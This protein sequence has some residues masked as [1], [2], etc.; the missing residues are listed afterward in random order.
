[1]Y[2]KNLNL[3]VID[4]PTLVVGF[5]TWNVSLG[6]YGYHICQK[7]QPLGYRCSYMCGSFPYLECNLE[8]IRLPHVCQKPQPLGYRC[9]YM[10]G[11]F[12]YLQCKLGFMRLPH[13]CQKPQPLGYRCSYPSGGFPYLECK[14]EFIR[15]PH[16]CQKPQPLGYRCSYLSGSFS[17]MECKLEFIR[18][19]HV[20]PKTSTSRLSVLLPKWWAQLD[21]VGGGDGWPLAAGRLRRMRDI[22]L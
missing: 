1:M 15:L 4:A 11:S 13:V 9:S 16:V 7:P 19:P 20:L 10:C 6:S 14:L 22:C 12:P 3:S 8:F 21:E 18:L 17:Y 2:A 5:P